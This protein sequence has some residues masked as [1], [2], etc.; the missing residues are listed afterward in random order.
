MRRKKGRIAFV[1]SMILMLLM[2]TGTLMAQEEDIFM[3]EPSV[4]KTEGIILSTVFPGLGQM[5]SGHKFKG[6]TLFIAEVAASAFLI[7]AHENYRT[8][9]SIYDSNKLELEGM[10]N[11]GNHLEASKRY[12][13]LK[14][15]F[16]ELDSLNKIRN[17]ALIVAAGVYVVN[18]VDAVIFNTYRTES[19]S[20]LYKETDKKPQVRISTGIINRSPGV[21]LTKIF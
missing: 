15:D 8:R 18:L 6:V 14:D 16:D 20:A 10:K 11:N 9:V 7:N 5:S 3:R 12:D 19:R 4:S 1:A 13:E 17:T 21:V 2:S